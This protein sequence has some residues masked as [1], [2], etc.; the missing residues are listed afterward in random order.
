NPTAGPG[1]YTQYHVMRR[2]KPEVTVILDGQGSDELFGGY[3][4]YF[5]ARLRDEIARGLGGRL[6]AAGLLAAVCWL[7]GAASVPRPFRGRIGRVLQGALARSAPRLPIAVEELVHPDLKARAASG[8]PLTRTT[9]PPQNGEFRDLLCDQLLNTSLP[10]LLHYEDR[11]SMAF[12][13]ESRVPFLD[14]RVVEFALSLP[15]E[16]KI[17]GTWTKWVLRKAAADVLPPEVA[18]RRSKMGYPTP[19]ARWFRKPTE[20]P[21]VEA[22]LFAPAADRGLLRPDKLRQVWELH[23]QGHDYSW[24]LYRALTLEL[25]YRHFMDDFV[26]APAVPN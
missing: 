17:R 1:L 11:N 26:P 23:Q 18:W 4:W 22:V 9:Y 5:A 2:A 21:G 24:L 25:W 7:W 20:R 10:A 8:P 3:L 15:A 12:S 13:L 14:Y 19:M 6:R 16:Y